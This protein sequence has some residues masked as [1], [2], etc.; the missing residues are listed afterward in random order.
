MLEAKN[1]SEEVMEV[2]SLHIRSV[3]EQFKSEEE[4]VRPVQPVQYYSNRNKEEKIGIP[5]VKLAKN[6]EIKIKF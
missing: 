1:T 4:E 5:I 2:T 6:Q 3:F